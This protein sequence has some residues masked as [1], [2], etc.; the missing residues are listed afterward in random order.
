MRGDD[1]LRA[2]AGQNVGAEPLIGR[3]PA[4]GGQRQQQGRAGV[5]KPDLGRVDPVPGGGAPG[6]EQ[7]IDR[8]RGGA[9][10]RDL[11][12]VAKGLAIKPALGM[13][14]EAQRL[15]QPPRVEVVRIEAAALMR[16]SRFCARA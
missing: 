7:K 8:G 4:V 14:R 12:A 11:K 10:R 16:E 5:K 3:R 2:L 13:R 6:F 1:G 9:A 15:D